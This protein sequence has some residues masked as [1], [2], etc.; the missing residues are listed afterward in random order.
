MTALTKNAI[1]G[2]TLPTRGST[3]TTGSAL[4]LGSGLVTAGTPLS[5]VESEDERSPEIRPVTVTST[6]AIRPMILA[7]SALLASR[8]VTP[9]TSAEAPPELSPKRETNVPLRPLLLG[10]PQKIPVRMPSN[11]MVPIGPRRKGL[12]GSVRIRNISGPSL[13]L[14]D[15]RGDEA[16]GAFER[17]RP[18]PLLLGKWK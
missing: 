4:V 13:P 3:L 15:G 11:T 9:T 10:T 14:D 17:P 1:S 6:Q 8:G 2:L 12:P 7:T 16:P 18:P 5:D